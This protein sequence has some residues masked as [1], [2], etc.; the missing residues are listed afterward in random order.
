MDTTR[1]SLLLRLNRDYSLP[2][3]G[4]AY[5]LRQGHSKAK[6]WRDKPEC[7][8]DALVSLLAFVKCRAM[9]SAV[10]R[11]AMQASSGAEEAAFVTG[12]TNWLVADLDARAGRWGSCRIPAQA[13]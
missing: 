4:V 5:E 9:N 3:C 7:C 12:V 1:A 6:S 13:A 2:W 8:S 11:P 10:G